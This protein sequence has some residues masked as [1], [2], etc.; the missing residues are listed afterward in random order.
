MQL[1]PWLCQRATDLPWLQVE[2]SW[3]VL[4]VPTE[5]DA[6]FSSCLVHSLVVTGL[7]RLPFGIGTADS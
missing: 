6:V 7:L 3:F 1:W 5:F 2:V 4:D